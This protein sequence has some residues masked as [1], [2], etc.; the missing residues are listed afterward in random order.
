MFSTK[1]VNP[2]AITGTLSWYKFSPLSACI[3][4]H[5]KTKISQETKKIARKFLELLLKPKVIK[6]ANPVKI[7]HGIIEQPHLID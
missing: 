2:G 3:I 6:M 4:N 5:F 7:E 1:E